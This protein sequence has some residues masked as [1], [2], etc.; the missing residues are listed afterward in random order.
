MIKENKFIMHLKAK[1]NIEII[2]FKNVLLE[3]DICQRIYCPKTRRF[4]LH[5]VDSTN[6]VYIKV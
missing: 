1:F 4:D 5:I 3:S 2:S 6:Q